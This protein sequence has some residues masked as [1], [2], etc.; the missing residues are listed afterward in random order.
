M[1]LLEHNRV[2]HVHLIGIIIDWFQSGAGGSIVILSWWQDTPWIMKFCSA[3]I[4]RD[5]KT[6][7]CHWK[8]GR[9]LMETACIFLL[10]NENTFGSIIMPWKFN[11]KNFI[12]NQCKFL[13][14]IFKYTGRKQPVASLLQRICTT[15]IIYMDYHLST[16]PRGKDVWNG[17]S[18]W[19][20]LSHTLHSAF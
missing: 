6:E 15:I 16:R 12:H 4:S 9:T 1:I 10:I 3:F 7:S 5:E 11:R 13:S 18:L 17:H 2:F 19:S 8:A 14:C 20:H